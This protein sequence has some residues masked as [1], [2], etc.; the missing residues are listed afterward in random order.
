MHKQT[1]TQANKHPNTQANK[2]LNI[3]KHLYVCF[4]EGAEEATA[5]CRQ[6]IQVCT[7]VRSVPCYFAPSRAL[8]G[9]L[10]AR[11]LLPERSG[12]VAAASEVQH[13]EVGST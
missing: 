9:H 11:T 4:I 12:A 2:H 8:A 5:A 10:E 6:R 1:N 7:C 13:G 3:P